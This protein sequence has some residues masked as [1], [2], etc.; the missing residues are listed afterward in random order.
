MPPFAHRASDNSRGFRPLPELHL[1]FRVAY[2]KHQKGNSRLIELPLDMSNPGYRSSSVCDV[3]VGL[4][5]K[6]EHEIERASAMVRSGEG[7]AT[8]RDLH[9]WGR[10][11]L[12]IHLD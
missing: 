8:V 2:G 5:R 3:L 10:C 1:P 7:R 11:V 6:G 12:A 9:G 4:P